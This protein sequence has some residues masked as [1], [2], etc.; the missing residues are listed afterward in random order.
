MGMNLE[1]AVPDINRPEM[2]M[3]GPASNGQAMAGRN[4]Q[5]YLA[6]LQRG[7]FDRRR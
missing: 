5:G 3:I 6:D 4:Y 1:R 7:V 2:S